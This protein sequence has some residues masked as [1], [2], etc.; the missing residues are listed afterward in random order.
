MTALYRYKLFVADANS[1][2]KIGF[3]PDSP[4]ETLSLLIDFNLSIGSHINSM[5]ADATG[6]TVWYVYGCLSGYV[7]EALESITL[8]QATEFYESLTALYRN[9]FGSHCRHQRGPSAPKENHLDTA[10]VMLWD[11]DSG[12]ERL[13]WSS[14]IER[15]SLGD[16]LIDFCLAHPNPTCQESLLHCLGHMIDFDHHDYA[17]QKLRAF[18]HRG[19]LH[20][21]VRVY[22]EQCLTG[23]IL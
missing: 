11:M 16:R 10:C 20:P 15:F 5:G 17:T 14:G 12:L 18:L 3:E 7:S 8:E 2:G 22:A 19:D 13:T 9:G 6:K 23:M 4:L 21:E 1:C